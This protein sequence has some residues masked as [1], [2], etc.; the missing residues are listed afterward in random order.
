MKTFNNKVSL[1]DNFRRQLAFKLAPFVRKLLLR[2]GRQASSFPGRVALKIYPNLLR[3]LCFDRKV[4]VVTGTNGKTSTNNM[5]AEI[6]T[7]AD[8]N[9]LAN[10]SGANMPD[11]IVSAIVA[12]AN[13][14]KQEDCHILVE[15]D[16]A[17]FAK[18]SHELNPQLV[19]LTNLFR[20][21]A[22]RYGDP[23]AT[24]RLL[25]KGLK[26][27][28]VT[29]IVANADEALVASIGQEIGLETCFVGMSETAFLS[30]SNASSPKQNP[31]DCPLCL[32]ELTY[33]GQVF[34]GVG[35]YTC[36]A[37][38]FRRPNPHLL[39]NVPSKSDSQSFAYRPCDS[40]IDVNSYESI[41]IDLSNEDIYNLYNAGTAALAAKILG[42]DWSTI[43]SALEAH[44][45]VEARNQLIKLSQDREVCV[46]LMKNP[47]GL[48]VSLKSVKDQGKASQVF[49]LLNNKENDGR[50]IT[51][52][53]EADYSYL[54]D[55]QED[56]KQIVVS[57][58][59]SKAFAHELINQGIRSDLIKENPSP[60]QAW[61]LVKKDL[62]TGERVYV[63]PNYTA[64][65]E[66]K[67]IIKS[68]D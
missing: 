13:K 47:V 21:Q 19:I 62:K 20:D 36:P 48:T 26:Q 64:M 12:Q 67:N 65:L 68:E 61:D 54:R 22:D 41:F 7:D 5:L 1:I 17:W 52:I 59:Q 55:I 32:R 40:N 18:I 51:W 15:V 31:Q 53:K 10:T 28:G 50:D 3:D 39:I 2:L 60:S 49:L 57:G 33:I 38:G 11:G 29:K 45:P 30:S 24:R 42:V 8:L 34:P 23:Y 66:L 58:S 44:E 9:V 14:L 6:L 43:K 25:I 56:L 16:E 63:L 35:D 27:G 46:I 4:I 37:C